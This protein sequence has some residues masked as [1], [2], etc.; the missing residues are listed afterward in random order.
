MLEVEILG[1][2]HLMLADTGGD[3]RFS[4]RNLIQALDDVL[5]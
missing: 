1:G 2:P 5:R 4:A 3:D